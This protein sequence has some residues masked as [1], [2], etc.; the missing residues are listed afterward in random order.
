[1]DAHSF[2]APKPTASGPEKVSAE[3]ARQ[4]EGDDVLFY[5]KPRLVNHLDA[6]ALSTVER[7]V[8]DLI[9]ED[10]P[11]I[12]DLMASWD[13]H[14][15]P[16]LDAARVVGLGL[17]LVELEANPRLTERVVHDLNRDPGIPWPNSSFDAVL[18]V[19]SVDYL[20]DP[21]A[22]FTEVNRVL[23]P[24]G[25]FLIVFSN[26]W[27]E[28]KVTRLWRA[29]TEGERVVLVE[30]WLRRAGGFGPTQAFVSKGQPRPKDDKYAGM[31]ITS[32]PVYAV[33]AEKQGGHSGRP[34]RKIRPQLV[35]APWTPEEVA[36]R[37]A[38]VGSTLACPHCGERLL[39]WAVPQ[40]PFTEWDNEF[41]YICF[42]DSCP[43]MLSGWEAMGRQGNL[44][45]S[46]R[47]MYNPA[48]GGCFPVPILSLKALRD[49][50][51][52]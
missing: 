39:K 10:R 27:F 41:M 44:G 31:G 2:E 37:Q 1:M 30:Q 4:D 32:D 43:Y 45:S 17:N 28:P 34:P 21:V 15:P 42:N 47:F 16:S 24:G 51:V 36:R 25:L 19:V 49:G 40:T 26:R 13:S 18:N 29:S 20:V 12:L 35:A 11:A 7:V 33:Y 8:G 5:T 14:L 38:R 48:N 50:I 52:D 23:K 22:V 46:Y 9:V 6:L 3:F